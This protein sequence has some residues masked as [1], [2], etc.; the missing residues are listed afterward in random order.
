VTDDGELVRDTRERLWAE[1]LELSRDDIRDRAPAE[2]IDE[3]WIPIAHDQRRRE[4]D[5]AVP[6]HRLIA[7]PGVSRRTRRLLGPLTGLID[8]G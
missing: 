7:L 5:G 8:D 2:L 4:S 6:S 1:H 3:L